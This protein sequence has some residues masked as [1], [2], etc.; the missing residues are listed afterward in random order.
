VHRWCHSACAT[1]G[2]LG[3]G[4]SAEKPQQQ[5]LSFALWQRREQRCEALAVLDQ[6]ELRLGLPERGGEPTAVS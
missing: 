4:E 2:D 5:D 1:R 6:V 3:L